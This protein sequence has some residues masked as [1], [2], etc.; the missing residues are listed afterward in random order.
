MIVTEGTGLAP[1]IR[2]MLGLPALPPSAHEHPLEKS[3]RS[4][5]WGCDGCGQSGQGKERY[6]CTQGCD[7]DFCGD[8]NAKAGCTAEKLAPQLA[9]LDI[10]SDG[11]YYL[12][13]QGASVTTASV[14]TFRYN[15]FCTP[16]N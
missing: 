9:L 11:A 8:C 7:F 6:R 5:G 15:L 4:S 14:E 12:A 1:R 3:D 10:P 2:G 13:N 16:T